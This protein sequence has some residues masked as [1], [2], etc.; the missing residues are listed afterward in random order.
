MMPGQI[1]KLYQQYAY[2]S[3][4]GRIVS[5]VHLIKIVLATHLIAEKTVLADAFVPIVK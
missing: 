4:A 2:R 1:F 3:E 5:S